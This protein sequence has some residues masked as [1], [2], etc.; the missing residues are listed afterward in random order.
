MRTP[1]RPGVGRSRSTRSNVPPDLAT[2]IAS[3]FATLHLRDLEEARSVRG[4]LDRPT[5]WIISAHG[6][7]SATWRPSAQRLG[8]E[9]LRFASVGRLRGLSP[10]VARIVVEPRLLISPMGRT[11]AMFNVSVGND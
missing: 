5:G 11:P 3:I 2:C 7:T 8:I 10:S 4:G 9:R 1:S 6:T